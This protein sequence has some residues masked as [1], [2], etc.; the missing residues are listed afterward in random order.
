MLYLSCKVMLEGEIS[1]RIRKA[2]GGRAARKGARV[3]QGNL[4]RHLPFYEKAYGRP[5][6]GDYHLR[7]RIPGSYPYGV[8]G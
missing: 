4:L 1:V 2:I 6:H 8:Y 7:Q 3:L 5:I